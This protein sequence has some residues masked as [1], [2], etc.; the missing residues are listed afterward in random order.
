MVTIIEVQNGLLALQ[1]QREVLEVRIRKGQKLLKKMQKERDDK[2]YH[3][4]IE[5]SMYLASD[6][7]GFSTN[8]FSF[9]YG[10]EELDNHPLLA[11]QKQ[12]NDRKTWSFVV[13]KD[14]QIL[15]KKAILPDHIQ[16]NCLNGLLA[17]IGYWLE[18]LKVNNEIK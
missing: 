17:G 9:Y 5:E 13:F 1:Q 14:N 11:L 7:A 10:Y 6:Y 2:V 3:P 8:T 16:W 15:Y 12:E 4:R 18:S